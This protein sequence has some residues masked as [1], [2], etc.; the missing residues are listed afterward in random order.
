MVSVAFMEP[1]TFEAFAKEIASA[2]DSCIV[3]RET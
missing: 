1:I 3:R 2:L